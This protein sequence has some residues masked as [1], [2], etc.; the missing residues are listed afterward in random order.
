[1][2]TKKV[3][4]LPLPANIREAD[5]MGYLPHVINLGDKTTIIKYPS[6]NEMILESVSQLVIDIGA[7]H[8]PVIN[9]PFKAHF[10]F[11]QIEAEENYDQWKER[12][13][14]HGLLAAGSK[15]QSKWAKRATHR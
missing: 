6:E 4:Q 12:L 10:K 15:L 13:R 1:M 5:E 8:L 7:D 11:G 9:V 14:F 2:S 3:S